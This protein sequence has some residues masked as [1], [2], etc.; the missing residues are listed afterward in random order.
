[1]FS[2]RCTNS[3][4][5]M[6]LSRVDQPQAPDT[7]C[8]KIVTGIQG[9]K[10]LKAKKIQFLQA[11]VACSELLSFSTVKV[12]VLAPLNITACLFLSLQFSLFMAVELLF[13]N[14]HPSINNN[15]TGFNSPIHTFLCII[16]SG[17]FTYCTGLPLMRWSSYYVLSSD[18]I[19][20]K[21]SAIFS[22][23]GRH[24]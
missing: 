12:R 2:E 7:D 17:S 23:H 8:G 18:I 22:W 11:P 24:A 5:Q 13:S 21:Y 16:P 20:G 9:G 14:M 4:G 15:Y 3:T 19:E 1:M 6:A 10:L